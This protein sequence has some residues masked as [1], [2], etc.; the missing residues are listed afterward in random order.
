MT[1]PY[2]NKQVIESMK[3]RNLYVEVVANK[4]VPK[5]DNVFMRDFV[6]LKMETI[7]YDDST[8]PDRPWK[9]KLER[10]KGEKANR[11]MQLSFR[12]LWECMG[13]LQGDHLLLNERAKKGLK[14]AL[15]T[16]ENLKQTRTSVDADKVGPPI[17][18]MIDD[19]RR[20]VYMYGNG[21]SLSGIVWPTTDHGLQSRLRKECPERFSDIQQKWQVWQ[22][23]KLV[24]TKIKGWNRAHKVDK[25]PEVTQY[26]AAWASMKFLRLKEEDALIY[27][28]HEEQTKDRTA[29]AKEIDDRLRRIQTRWEDWQSTHAPKRLD[30]YANRGVREFRSEQEMGLTDDPF[31]R[32][33][34]EDEDCADYIAISESLSL[35]LSTLIIRANEPGLVNDREVIG[36]ST[37]QNRWLDRAA[38]YNETLKRHVLAKKTDETIKKDG[39][40]NATGAAPAKER[41]P[42]TRLFESRIYQKAEMRTLSSFVGSRVHQ[43]LAWN[44]A[45]KGAWNMCFPPADDLEERDDYQQFKEY[46]TT[47]GVQTKGL[48]YLDNA[49]HNYVKAVESTMKRLEWKAVGV[50]IP[51]VDSLRLFLRESRHQWMES[52][53]DALCVDKQGKIVL[54]DYKNK[55]GFKTQGDHAKPAEWHQV[56]TYAMLMALNYGIVVD[57]VAVI[58]AKRN[59]TVDVERCEFFPMAA[60]TKTRRA[61]KQIPEVQRYMERLWWPEQDAKYWYVD[62]H[63]VANAKGISWLKEKRLYK[64]LYLNRLMEAIARRQTKVAPTQPSSQ[65]MTKRGPL[66]NMWYQI[67]RIG[68]YTIVP[69][70]RGEERPPAF[71]GAFKTFGKDELRM[72]QIG[73][74]RRVQ[75][76]PVNGTGSERD[77]LNVAVWDEAGALVP[78]VSAWSPVGLSDE[79]RRVAGRE[80]DVRPNGPIQEQGEHPMQTFLCRTLNRLINKQLFDD[81]LQLEAEVKPEDQMSVVGMG[82]F[83]HVSQ[84]A[85]WSDKQLEHARKVYLPAKRTRLRIALLDCISAYMPQ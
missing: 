72:D 2:T 83:Q 15:V 40:S 44:A 10:Y 28:T 59:N 71:V 64:C 82:L 29:V 12:G 68:L 30:L 75:S 67:N 73:W 45:E 48:G 53:V 80:L 4:P 17:P 54:V 76:E 7:E 6:C 24:P 38:T 78:L 5:K 58:I 60:K 25:T 84:R 21:S 9:I 31:G 51:V 16:S 20:Y 50:E 41:E 19:E 37:Q 14:V 26:G 74:K 13:A 55:I 33:A 43:I 66:D 47:S 57:S 81:V 35:G 34:E 61:A 62:D 39:R 52:R 69:P 79:L 56:F 85:L 22:N 77:R 49:V 23:E 70:S 8:S 11:V 63:F 18:L 3:L 32:F 46:M 1:T 42:V 65:W 36:W 27:G